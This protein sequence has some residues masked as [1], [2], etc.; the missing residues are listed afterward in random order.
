MPRA[1]GAKP[2][3]GGAMPPQ[4]IE[5]IKREKEF[6][7]QKQLLAMSERGA[8]TRAG[9]AAG[10]QLGAAKIGAESRER[11][12]AGQQ[13]QAEKRDERLEAM[14]D[15]QAAAQVL[16]ADKNKDFSAEQAKIRR[17]F[18]V[19]FASIKRDYEIADQKR[20]EKL[21]KEASARL[22]TWRGNLLKFMTAQNATGVA[23]MLRMA[24]NFKQSQETD[25]KIAIDTKAALTANEQERARTSTL[26]EQIK[27]A[28]GAN[29][30]FS[31]ESAVEQIS[32]TRSSSGVII[33]KLVG[34]L[35]P[36]GRPN[37]GFSDEQMAG[38]GQPPTLEGWPVEQMDD[39]LSKFGATGLN[40]GILSNKD[41]SG[42]AGLLSQDLSTGGIG[43]GEISAA[44]HVLDQLKMYYD[45]S[46]LGPSIDKTKEDGNYQWS[47][48]LVQKITDAQMNIMSVSQNRNNPE[49]SK[50]AMA[51]MQRAAGLSPA[52]I[53]AQ[54]HERNP[55]VSPSDMLDGALRV[56]QENTA[57]PEFEGTPEEIA[58]WRAQYNSSKML[59]AVRQKEGVP[60]EADELQSMQEVELG[61]TP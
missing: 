4:V 1:A 17:D 5:G 29:S 54:I 9:M 38:Y 34:P 20:D 11:V 30:N 42:L 12:A 25:A 10:A 57:M 16:A 56:I 60:T 3:T 50:R 45:T 7:R 28:I 53:R 55:G 19:E 8:T 22:Q 24:E 21:L 44:M 40:M 26:L 37:T 33:D 52:A 58:D 49:A 15:K 35:M 32:S 23:V 31:Y 14:A 43:P 61:G 27:A 2:V 39:L 48:R 18:E 47:Q 6:L 51:G 46:T 41:T 59:Q 36:T 13:R